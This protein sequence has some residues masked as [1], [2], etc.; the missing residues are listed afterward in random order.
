MRVVHVSTH[1]SLRDACDLVKRERVL[2]VIRLAH[3]A[4]RQLGIERPRI[5]VA[6]LNPHAGESGIFGN[7]EEAEISPAIG[8]GERGD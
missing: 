2:A 4:C 7:E 8:D 1:V 6:G 5:G 3:E